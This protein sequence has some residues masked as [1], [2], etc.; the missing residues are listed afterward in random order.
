M[1]GSLYIVSTP[2]GN[3]DDITVRARR[4]LESVQLIAAE[5]TRH[6]GQLLQALD[7]RTPLVSYHDHNESER[8]AQLLE[9]LEAG[10]DLAL[11]SD[12]GTP[13]VSDPGFRLVRAARHAGVPVVPVPGASALLAALVVAGL[14]TDAFHFQGFLPPKGGDRERALAG[15][16]ARDCTSVVYESP[17]RVLALLRELEARVEPERQLVLCRELTKRFETVLD[18]TVADVRAAVEADAN[19]QRGEIV[20][21]LSAAPP[22]DAGEEELAALAGPLLQEL[23]ASRAAKV[24]AAWT[25]RKRQDLYRWLEDFQQDA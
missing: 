18:G 3:L 2:I 14:P 15:L 23:P 6:S 17:R 10:E 5:D 22:R 24:L 1:T 4:V 16:A 20:L 7:V 19:Q 13:L 25:G 8:T 12:A 11:I 21:V 9:K